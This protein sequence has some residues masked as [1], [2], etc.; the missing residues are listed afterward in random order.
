MLNG[1]PLLAA[2]LLAVGVAV[3]PSA[4]AG[5]SRCAG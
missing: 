2:L 3:V 5:D 4:G 1:V